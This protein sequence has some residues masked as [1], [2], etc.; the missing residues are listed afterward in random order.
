MVRRVCDPLSVRWFCF[1][2]ALSTL[3]TVLDKEVSY[4]NFK[5]FLYHSGERQSQRLFPMKINSETWKTVKGSIAPSKKRKILFITFHKEIPATMKKFGLQ[6]WTF[7]LIKA[8]YK[9][10]SGLLF[11]ESEH[12]AMTARLQSFI[13][14]IVLFLPNL[15][16]DLDDPIGIPQ[17]ETNIGTRWFLTD[18]ILLRIIIYRMLRL[19]NK[20]TQEKPSVVSAYDFI[21]VGAGSAGWK[22]K[23]HN[24]FKD[25]ESLICGLFWN[26]WKIQNICKIP[27]SSY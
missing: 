12:L 25:R 14:G 21:V 7:E 26:I 13:L 15:F 27:L 1:R 4:E 18:V 16:F 2:W 20:T 8:D 19:Q 10:S 5:S 3:W 23:I 17:V 9:S 24:S 11:F 22:N 6:H